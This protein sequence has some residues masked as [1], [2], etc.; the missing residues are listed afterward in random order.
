MTIIEKTKNLKNP[1]GS[2]RGWNFLGENFLGG[3]QQG[4]V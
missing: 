1:G 4:V 3:I 2:I